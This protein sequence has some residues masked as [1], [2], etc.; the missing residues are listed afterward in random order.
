M[1]EIILKS[2]ETLE[3]LSNHFGWECYVDYEETDYDYA[4]GACNA[5][6]F[7]NG[8]GIVEFTN[9][10][11]CNSRI[12]LQSELHTIADVLNNTTLRVYKDSTQDFY[13][14]EG[15]EVVHIFDSENFEELKVCETYA[16]FGQKNNCT[17][18]GCCS[19]HNTYFFKS[20][21]D[22]D[23]FE[24][25][26][27]YEEAVKAEFEEKHG[28]SEHNTVSG[29]NFWDGSNWQTLVLKNSES[30]NNDNEGLEELDFKLQAK[31]LLEFEEKKFVKSDFGIVYYE[32]ENYK[33]QVSLF[34]TNPYLAD[35]I[36]SI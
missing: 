6:V 35:V 31:I 12:I 16:Q 17:D 21:L 2:V 10:V 9:Y 33:F 27:E 3:N 11:K 26:E 5:V 23:N 15:N 32:S 4:E 34:S 28:E 1:S 20:E 13:D 7:K 19:I 25:D 18:A 14:S 30:V 22:S 29:Y 8:E 24:S 36:L